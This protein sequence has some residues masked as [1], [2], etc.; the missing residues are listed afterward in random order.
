MYGG[1]R[2]LIRARAAAHTRLPTNHVRLGHHL[3][4]L[5]STQFFSIFGWVIL[6]YWACWA[7]RRYIRIMLV[8]TSWME[9][10]LSSWLA[11]VQP[12]YF[13]YCWAKT[14]FT[15]T[16][17]FPILKHNFT[18]FY[19]PIITIV[20]VVWIFKFVTNRPKW[21]SVL[22]DK[23]KKKSNEK[24][25]Q[26]YNFQIKRRFFQKNTCYSATMFGKVLYTHIHVDYQC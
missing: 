24:F 8:L 7:M 19:L 22:N 16:F 21:E 15:I 10:F 23:K 9:L 12:R 25:V 18:R 4:C 2:R 11:C 14:Y 1:G 20:H 26:F 3:V 6:L 5:L 13:D 17:L